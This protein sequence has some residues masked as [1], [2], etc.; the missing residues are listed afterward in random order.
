MT[1]RW[2]TTERR[3]LELLADRAVFG[4]EGRERLEFA[5]LLEIM[6]HADTE[7]M[8]RAAAVV[9]LARTELEPLPAG[10]ADRVRAAALR[11]L[12]PPSQ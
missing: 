8:E 10:V 7:C 6:P 2:Q 11:H 3:L 5:E 9:L 4:M 12:R 1:D